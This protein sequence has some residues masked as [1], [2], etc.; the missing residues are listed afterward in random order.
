MA[1]EYENIRVDAVDQTPQIT[2]DLPPNVIF[3][4]HDVN[5]GLEQYY[6][7]YDLV[8]VRCVGSGIRSYR[9]L[10]EEVPK[11]LKPGGVAIFME[12][13][14]DLWSE[15]RRSLQVP[16]SDDNPNGSWLQRWMQGGSIPFL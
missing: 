8:H 2:S 16:A 11:C 4:N 1:T 5:D 14:F 9:R 10:L 12:G 13:D 6:G 15:D 3:R 7:E